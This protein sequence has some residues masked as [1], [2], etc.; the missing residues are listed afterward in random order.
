MATVELCLCQAGGEIVSPRSVQQL[1]EC[2][3]GTGLDLG[4]QVERV[5]SHCETGFP[6]VHL[7]FL[8]NGL[9]GQLDSAINN[10]ESNETKTCSQSRDLTRKLT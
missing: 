2:S 10:P 9:G 1:S 4:S 5:N 7:S 8:V 3:D 6:D